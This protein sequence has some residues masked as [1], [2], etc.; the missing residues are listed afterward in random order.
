MSEQ[1]NQTNSKDLNFDPNDFKDTNVE[2]T[3]NLT[4]ENNQ[5]TIAKE[6]IKYN[7]QEIEVTLDELKTHAQKG[8]NYDKILSERDSLKNSEELAYL[9]ELADEKG[10]DTKTLIKELKES[11]QKEKIEIR[12]KELEQSEGL[13]PQQALKMAELELK[14]NQPIKQEKPT[15]TIQK[16]FETLLR[17]FPETREQFKEFKDLPKPVADAIIDGKPVALA[18]AKYLVEESNKAKEIALQE[19]DASKRTPGTLNGVDPQGKKD[20]FLDGFWGNK[21]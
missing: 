12:A 19:L 1:T 21:R 6:K 20:E 9:K 14:V 17:E 18:Y 13:N 11:K 8:L 16:E 4:E 2:E 10:V 5:P 15:D 3:S 7:G